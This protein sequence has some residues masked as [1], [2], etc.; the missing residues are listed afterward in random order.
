MKRILLVMMQPPGSS[1]VQGLIYNKILP[2]LEAYGWEFHFAGPNP[3]LA[4][5]KTESV[6]CP[7]E[8]LHYTQN[9][10]WSRRFSV[11]KNR[12]PKKSPLFLLYGVGQLLSAW[13][14]KLL[15][16]DPQAHLLRGL[17][18]TVRQADRQCKYDLIAGKSPD[19]FILETVAQISESLCKPLVA[20]VI[21]PY[22]E[23][24]GAGFYPYE[25]EKQKQIL[26][27]AC[28]AMFMSPMTELATLATDRIAYSWPTWA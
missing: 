27:Q 20:M 21:D 7:A 19:F 28:G 2:Y 4:S 3:K 25:A 24:N 17:T 5:V 15:H 13:I 22:G 14:E 16:H 6:P 26:S 23:R 18:K 8:R 11:L 9:I 10:S 12:Q 1:G